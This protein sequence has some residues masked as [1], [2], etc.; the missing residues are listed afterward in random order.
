MSFTWY[1][2][3]TKMISSFYDIEYYRVVSNLVT[4]QTNYQYLVNIDVY[5]EEPIKFMIAPHPVYTNAIINPFE[6]VK[7]YHTKWTNPFIKAITPI[8]EYDLYEF[9]IYVSGRT[10]TGILDVGSTTKKNISH[11]HINQIGEDFS[12]ANYL[13]NSVSG[14]FLNKFK[15]NK[16]QLNQSSTLAA[17]NGEFNCDAQNY[18]NYD[19]I[20]YLFVYDDGSYKMC[21]LNIPAA[22]LRPVEVSGTTLA[23][24]KH[25]KLLIPSGTMNI[26]GLT[27]LM[28]LA[29]GST[30]PI[31]PYTYTGG[32]ISATG[33][34]I[35]TPITSNTKEYYICGIETA[36]ITSSSMS[37]LVQSEFIKYKVYCDMKGLTNYRLMWLNT[38]GGYDFYN[39][40]K[41]ST[42]G[43]ELEKQEFRKTNFEWN[44]SDMSYTRKDKNR[45]Q[46][47][48][49]MKGDETYVVTSDLLTDDETEALK[50]IYYSPD[51]YLIMSNNNYAYPVQVTDTSI[52]VMKNLPTQLS[53]MIVSFKMNEGLRLQI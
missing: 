29:S 51:V 16:I 12:Y 15:I 7:S 27:E 38:L 25:H 3:N 4:G 42:K 10:S 13:F 22:S 8:G 43:I 28:L 48:Y 31:N 40:N 1:E 53:Q 35:T 24:M 52:E 6:V 5:D 36:I 34:T 19:A 9:M 46:T 50:Y 30:L 11:N 33:T 23:S 17:L 18:T 26:N 32:V 49:N 37:I 41:K 39:F 45:V 47:W 21:Y 20:L 44:L 2:N 14:K